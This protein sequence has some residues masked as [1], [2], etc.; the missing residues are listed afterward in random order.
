MAR[1]RGIFSR[2]T[3]RTATLRSSRALP[4]GLHPRPGLAGWF[5][6]LRTVVGNSTASLT[7]FAFAALAFIITTVL[8]LPAASASG[9]A[10]PLPDAMFTAVS[11]ITVTGLTTVDMATHW[12]P[13]GHTVV[14]ISLQL[15][16]IGVMTVATLLAVI[17]SN[18]WDSV[19]ARG[20][21]EMSTRRDC[22]SVK[23][24]MPT[25]CSWGM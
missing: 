3:S 4:Y 25:A 8:M 22:T 1:R 15:G 9:E 17:A 7:I 23:R 20:W 14:F 12:S 11:A 18:V 10:T 24:S 5:D 21:P 6:R 19:H 16:G 2:R 13:L